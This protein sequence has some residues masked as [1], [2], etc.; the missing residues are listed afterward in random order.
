M[1]PASHQKLL[2]TKFSIS[3]PGFFDRREFIV[4]QHPMD[5]TM[6]SFWRMVWEQE[7]SLVVVLS[8]I[9]N[10]VTFICISTEMQNEMFENCGTDF[11]L[12]GTELYS[13]PN[14]IVFLFSMIG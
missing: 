11:K 6:A 3:F 7:S 5:N 13:N 2:E 10:Q 9:D 14:Y 4:T 1:V 12:I 8:S